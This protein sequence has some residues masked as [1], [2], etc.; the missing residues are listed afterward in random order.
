MDWERALQ[1]VPELRSLPHELRD[2]AKC[3]T[4]DAREYLFRLGVRPRAVFCLLN[5]EVRLVRQGR[6][7]TEVVLQRCDGGFL[8]EASMDAARYHCDALVTET[9]DLLSFPIAAFQ[10][11]LDTHPGFR[12]AWISRLAG[13]VRRLRAQAER[14]CLNSARDRVIH[15]IESEGK[16]GAIHLR[17]SR[18]AWAQELGLSHEALYRT[19]SRLQREG[20]LV[21]DGTQIRLTPTT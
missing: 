11:A 5:G 7:G 4:L 1:S 3:R 2:A 19:L 20:V 16:N 13:E 15:Y 12:E 8:A 17:H 21:V 9:A 18:K 14:L 6:D 10:Q